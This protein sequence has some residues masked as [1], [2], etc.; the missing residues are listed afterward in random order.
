MAVRYESIKTCKQ[1][2]ARLGPRPY[3]AWRYRDTG[4]YASR[5]TSNSKNNESGRIKTMD[6]HIILSNTYHLVFASWT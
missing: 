1:S 6:A 5:H 4:I 2:G 3:A